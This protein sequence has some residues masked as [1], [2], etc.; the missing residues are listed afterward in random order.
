[1]NMPIPTNPHH[2]HVFNGMA[3]F[4]KC[5]IKNFAFIMTPITKL[6]RKQNPLFGPSNVKKLGIRS[7]KSTWKNKF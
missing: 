5:F 3:Q 7:N 1:M 4:Y 2:I 6:M